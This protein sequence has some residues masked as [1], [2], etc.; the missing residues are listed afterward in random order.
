[1]AS[2]IKLVVLAGIFLPIA[3]NFG[4]RDQKL[5][6]IVIMLA[7]PC[8][9]TSYIMAKNMDGDDTLAASIVVS[10]TLFSSITLTGWIFLMKALM[11]IQ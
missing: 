8:T 9:P 4:F 7:S 5:I 2:L 3:A 1:M 6:A 11:L 10:T